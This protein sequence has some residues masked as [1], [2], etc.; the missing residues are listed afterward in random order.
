MLTINTREIYND[1]NDNIGHTSVINKTKYD[2]NTTI[3]SQYIIKLY[4]YEYLFS[5]NTPKVFNVTDRFILVIG[6]Q[7]YNIEP[8]ILIKNSSLINQVSDWADVDPTQGKICFR[9]S[10]NDSDLLSD[11]SGLSSKDYCMQVL[12]VDGTTQ[13]PY[14][15]N[16]SKITIKNVTVEV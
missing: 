16:S 13:L 11:I 5:T 4:C 7:Q 2:I 15:V 1:A 6:V 14:L 9:V 8:F 10:L 12:C 3:Q